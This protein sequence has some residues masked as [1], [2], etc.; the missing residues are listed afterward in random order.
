[1]PFGR[2]RNR[3]VASLPES[4][5]RW[6]QANVR[7]REPLNSEVK[8]T[9]GD[10]GTLAQV[11]TLPPELRATVL[12]VVSVGYRMLALRA[13]PDRA[14]GR[15]QDMVKLNQAVNWLRRQAA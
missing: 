4:Y 3:E 12:E 5:L 1:M 2:Y 13:H 7:L 6:L 10:A 14:S 11:S 9:L 8:R 15:H